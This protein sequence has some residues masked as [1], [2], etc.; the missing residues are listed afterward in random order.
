[1]KA[2]NRN[3]ILIATVMAVVLF[4]AFNVIL[5]RLGGGLK[6][7]LTQDRLYT[8]SDSTK[9]VLKG[10]E[11]PLDATFF[12]S[13]EAARDYPQLF[14]YGRRIRD[15][16][17]EYQAISGGRL[18]VRFVDPKPFSPEEDE[19]VGAGLQGVPTP[20][21]RKIYLGLVVRDT[22]DRQAVI[23][24]FNQER[25]DLLEYD[26]TKVIANVAS[27]ERPTVALLTA[28]PMKP[29]GL[30][31]FGQDSDP[32]WAIY[33]QLKQFFTIEDL[34]PGFRKIPEGTDILVIIHPPKLDD[35]QLY[36]IDQF[37]LK[38]GRAVIFVDPFSEASVNRDPRN[39]AAFVPIS[40]DKVLGRLFAKWGV[41]VVPGKI[42][43]DRG[44]AQRVNVGGYGPDSIKSYPLWLHVDPGHLDREDPVTANLET[45]N[46]ASVG[47]IHA[48]EGAKTT[49][50]PLLRSSADSVLVDA[51]LGRGIPDIDGFW[52]DF[53]PD[54]KTYDLVVRVNGAVD[55]AFPD[56]PPGIADE[57][58]DAGKGD[59]KPD[60]VE[61]PAQL[62]HSAAP[63]H[64]II[65]A[66]SDLF[67][68]RF[69][70][71]VQDFMG[72]KVFVPMADN[73]SLLANAVDNLAGSDAL[74]SL[75]GRGVK[76]RPFV[77][78]EELRRQAEDRLLE[79]ERQLQQELELTQKRLDELES[80]KP[81]GGGVLTPA[82]EEEIERFRARVLEI[83]HQLRAVQRELVAD[84]ERLKTVLAVINI[85][86][87]PLLL[88]V[89]SLILVWVRRRRGRHVT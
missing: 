55:T 44:L 54:E 41:E 71:R 32:G 26:L 69:W 21:G 35:G 24:F 18:K 16:L 14:A 87:V 19:A 8:I 43:A 46:M 88:V 58:K 22:T 25:E 29:K 48:L 42:I 7:D 39:P 59:G 6:I 2:A 51:S 68:D 27:G 72:R 80:K 67:D 15:L 49:I 23:P 9:K 45:V 85:L 63:I 53:K 60:A 82:Q 81:E 47:A 62:E 57:R 38:G 84:I 66:D 34:S 61:G 20:D 4:F 50:E 77:V 36:L 1:M 3:R 33:D 79:K 13:E 5:E 31:G 37:V 89:G 83:R 52:K 12:F 56:G 10:L 30:P 17:R 76:E 11:D 28:L 70:V 65:G 40:S 75:R 64:L 86:L 73:A 74:I 78:V